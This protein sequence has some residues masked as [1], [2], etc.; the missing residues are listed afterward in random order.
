MSGLSEFLALSIPLLTIGSLAGIMFLVIYLDYKKKM[1]MILKGLTPEDEKHKPEN[2]LGWGIIILGAGI[3]LIIS[4][5]FNLDDKITIGL[6]LVSIG[7]ALLVPYLILYKTRD[8][9]K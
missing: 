7:I 1:A 2:K 6:I 4:W 3:S 9:P 8:R 5:I